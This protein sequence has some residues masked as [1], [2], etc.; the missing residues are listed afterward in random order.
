MTNHSK[1][2][3]P[4][5]TACH[6]LYF[7]GLRA[8]GKTTLGRAV[9]HALDRPF[10]DTDAAVEAACGTTIN[11]LVA[12]SGW[13]A[14][15]HLETKILQELAP[16][17]AQVVSTG[18]GIVLRAE[19]RKI[20]RHSG[21][22]FYLLAEPALLA[23]RLVADPNPDQRPALQQSCPENQQTQ[24]EIMQEM[25]CLLEEREPLYMAVA[26]FVLPAQ[27]PV[28]TLLQDVLDTLERLPNRPAMP[29]V[30]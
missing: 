24:E 14:F 18:G 12:S 22:V 16:S 21:P 7:T 25:A 4:E 2:T 26:N 19:N 3:R 8:S 30:L 15:R 28:N 11:K 27:E 10:V 23:R 1:Y 6:T 29:D 9:A 13:E 20:L 17:K 5:Y